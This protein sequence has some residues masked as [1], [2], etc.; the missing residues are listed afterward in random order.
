ML[1]SFEKLNSWESKKNWYKM[2]TEMGARRIFFQGWAMRGSE[3][4][5]SPSRVQGQLPGGAKPP[6]ADIFSK[7]CRNTSSTEVLDNMC[8][9]KHF[10]TF[11]G[12]TGASAPLPCPWCERPRI[13]HWR[14]A[15]LHRR[16]STSR[17]Y[18]TTT[19]AKSNT[20]SVFLTVTYTTRTQTHR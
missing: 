14:L 20:Y 3:G 18:M 8:G 17:Q 19:F 12:G 11:P 10:S 4:R 5:K 2:M 7:W 1:T 6:E 9:K 16:A 13:K 15:G